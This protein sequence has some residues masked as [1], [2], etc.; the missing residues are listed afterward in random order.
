MG[1]TDQTNVA[2]YNQFTGANSSVS[3][4]APQVST[5]T[6]KL[7]IAFT[8]YAAAT[9]LTLS[10]IAADSLTGPWSGIAR[11]VNGAA[12]TAIAPVRW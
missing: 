4:S 10:V 5:T 12:F 7:K 1:G 6:G 9:D 2:I 8:R 11:S 3:S